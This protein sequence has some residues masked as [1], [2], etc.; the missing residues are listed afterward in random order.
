M[1]YPNTIEHK[2]GFDVI[3]CDLAE[4]CISQGSKI[5]VNEMSFST[6]YDTINRQ[7]TQVDEMCKINSSSELLQIIEVPNFDEALKKISIIGFY[8]SA[9]ELFELN[10]VLSSSLE[11]SRFFSNKVNEDGFTPYPEL[12]K[13]VTEINPLQQVAVIISRVIDK[14][15]NIKDS[16]SPELSRIRREL[17][18]LSGRI[19]SIMKRVVSKAITDGVLSPETNPSIRDGRLVIPVQPMHKRSIPGI[20]HDESSSGKTYFVEPA[21][22]VE[23]NNKIRELQ[24][25]EKQE[26][27]KILTAVTD[28][29]RPYLP[30]IKQDID[31]LYL[32]DFIHAKSLFAAKTGC[33]KPTISK[34]P[35]LEWYHAVHPVLLMT[36]Q[37]HN[38]E[39]VP[40]DLN[41]SKDKRI[42]IISGPNAGGKSVCLKTVGV[43]QYMLQCGMLPPVYENSHV[44]IFD[45]LFIDIGDDQSIEDDLSTYSSHL[46]NMKFFTR[47]CDSNT[48]FLIDEFGGGTEPLIGGAIAQAIL[49]DIN[50]KKSWGVI[51]TH[52]QNLKQ[53][54]EE[55]PGIINGSMLYDKQQMRP[56]FKLSVGHPGSSFAIEI[57]RKIGLPQTIISDA[58]E[59]VGS[60][61]INFDKYLSDIIRDKKYW[62][63]RR[64]EIKKKEKK[65]D[66]II[67]QYEDAA[68]TL[69]EQRKTIISQAK[70]EAREIL[71]KS[72]AAIERAIHDIRKSQAE[73]NATIEARKTVEKTK[74]ELSPDTAI[75]D[76]PLL[77][78]TPQKKRQPKPQDTATKN[79]TLAVGDNV[80]LDGEG[81]VGVILEIV[82]KNAVTAFGNLKTS[83]PLKRLKYTTA[84]IR[85]AQVKSNVSVSDSS[86]DRLLN[87]KH[88]IDVRGMR[89][90][91][92]V[93]AVTYF[94]DDAVQFNASIVRI[95]HGTGTG[96]LRQVIR[97]YLNANPAVK[98]FRDEDVRFGGAGITVVELE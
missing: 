94:I 55:T 22:I 57:A 70:D 66:E 85:E 96:A 81:T 79:H 25:E 58:Q 44:G 33:T 31:I 84:K 17:Q 43:V 14:F 53:F 15:G 13:I 35:E 28:E 23:A 97:Q 87:F 56:L 78:N 71:A 72:N 75:S 11:I 24:I 8:L 21:E 38:K 54:G 29:L 3:R 20:I 39:M 19:S 74:T 41:L 32:L 2:I 6:D 26:I 98:S 67:T 76:H 12:H 89:A 40:L 64:L 86:R 62:E 91:E 61:Y 73:K 10:R 4:L 45:K 65:I 47:N 34:K 36:L 42:L 80:K 90:D 69:R 82:G 27:I 5:L 88:E 1:I 50:E 30:D 60:D 52:F 95:L 18:H 68:S 49:K 46:K 16:A 37:R 48:L 93:Q 59:I 63:N 9:K 77:K 7:I 51:T 92:A 83:V